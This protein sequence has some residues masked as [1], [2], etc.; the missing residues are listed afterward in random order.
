MINWLQ[1]HVTE[2]IL[3]GGPK[4]NIGAYNGLLRILF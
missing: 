4:T 1:D 3:G 2:N